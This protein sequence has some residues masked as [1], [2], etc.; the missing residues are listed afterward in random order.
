MLQCSENVREGG[1]V[2][3]VEVDRDGLHG[4]LRRHRI[5]Q[6][7]QEGVAIIPRRL[8][9]EAI[10]LVVFIAGRGSDRRVETIAE[11]TG[12]DGNGDYRVSTL[13]LSQQQIL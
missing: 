5:E 8:I 7:V 4:D 6:L 2:C 9:A 12:L 10:D 11:V 1:A 13:S 3:V